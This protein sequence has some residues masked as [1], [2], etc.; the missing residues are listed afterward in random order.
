M[1]NLPAVTAPN[2]Q[3]RL[4]VGSDRRDQADRLLGEPPGRVID[5]RHRR[6]VEPL[7]PVDR[8]HQWAAG[9]EGPDRPEHRERHGEL[10]RRRSVR[11]LQEERDLEGLTLRPRQG[12]QLLGDGVAE[13]VGQP[14]VRKTSLGFEGRRRQHAIPPRLGPVHRHAPEGGLADA[15]R[16]LDR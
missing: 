15:E 11:L 13:Q 7:H 4:A 3:C 16:P 2:V 9:R 8:D 1:V 10:V 12:R 5:G 6:R 14:R